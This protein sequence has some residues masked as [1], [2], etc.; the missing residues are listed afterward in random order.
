MHEADLFFP[1]SL[2]AVLK[3]FGLEFCQGKRFGVPL[4]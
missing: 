4:A 3:R 2:E 1:N